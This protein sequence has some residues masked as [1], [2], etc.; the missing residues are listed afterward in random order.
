[1]RANM[2]NSLEELLRLASAEFESLTKA[3]MQM[4]VSSVIGEIAECGGSDE[5]NNLEKAHE[6]SE[7][8]II[9]AHLIRWLCT[10]KLASTHIDVRGIRVTHAKIQGLLD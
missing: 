3:E 7:E 10:N 1:M 4:I 2:G 9:H 8:R 6:W 5:E